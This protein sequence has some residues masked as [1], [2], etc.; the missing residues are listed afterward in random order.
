MSLSFE[1]QD[2]LQKDQYELK[3]NLDGSRELGGVLRI[4]GL[5]EG[6]S[7]Y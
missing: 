1:G 4:Y 3:S 7:L 5:R 6:S 2:N